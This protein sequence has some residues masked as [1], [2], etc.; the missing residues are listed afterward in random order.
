MKTAAGPFEVVT[1]GEP[2]VSIF[3]Q[4]GLSLREDALL[5][6]GW[7]GDTLDTSVALGKLGH[8]VAFVTRTSTDAFGDSLFDLLSSSGV[9]SVFVQRDSHRPTGLCFVAYEGSRHRFY[10]YRKDSAACFVD[11]RSIDWDLLGRAKVLHLSGISQGISPEALE[12]SFRLM[13]FARERGI[14]VSYDINY[15]P[16]LWC[17]ELSRAIVLHTIEQ[18]VDILQMTAEELTL[19][20]WEPESF[21]DSL[22]RVPSIVA[23]KRGAKG[24]SLIQDDRR[25][26][27]D[28]LTVDVADTV[29]AGD[30][31][32]AGLI[33][34]L[35]KGLDLEGLGRMAN[36][37]AALSCRGRGP[38]EGQPTRGEVEALVLGE[39]DGKQR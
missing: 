1:Y 25:V 17:R 12:L 7:G 21:L 30:A 19:L 23:L 13:G 31:F 27:L 11:G 33:A 15:R 9:G 6:K 20:G 29:G 32:A 16:A 18:Y 8:S 10:Y 3:A 5:S 37:V 35:L 34:G 14:S 38:L 22:V 2:L 4:P 36:A 28:P 24:C 26:E 39:D